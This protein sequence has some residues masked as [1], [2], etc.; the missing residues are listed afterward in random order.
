MWKLLKPGELKK[1][2]VF[3]LEPALRFSF[4]H[5]VAERHAKSG[6]TPPCP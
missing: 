3:L 1:Y 6:K 5:T 2:F 4:K